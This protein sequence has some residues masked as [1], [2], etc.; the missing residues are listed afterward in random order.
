MLTVVLKAVKMLLTC[1]IKNSQD[2]VVLAALKAVQD[3][4]KN[5]IYKDHIWRLISITDKPLLD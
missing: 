5:H 3:V 1:C 4:E 2:A